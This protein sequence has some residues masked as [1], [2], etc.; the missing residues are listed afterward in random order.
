MNIVTIPYGGK[1]HYLRP[2]T[3]YNKDRNDYFCPDP[4]TQLAAVPFMYI[5]IDKAAK[6]VSA[7]FA[8]RYYSAIG[9]GMRLIA[10]ELI[11][12]GSP[13]TWWLANSLDLSTYFGDS[14]LPSEAETVLDA[15]RTIASTHPVLTAPSAFTEKINSS[16]EAVTQYTSLKTG[17]YLTLDLTP[18]HA[19]LFT[20][21]KE[22]TFVLGELQIRIIW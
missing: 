3:S 20:K 22:D 10:P 7:K 13:E 4:I 6:A 14:V 9:Y 12:P 8:S 15:V 1:S 19:Y 5:R 21:G 2:D 18:E 11:I 17:D 16:L